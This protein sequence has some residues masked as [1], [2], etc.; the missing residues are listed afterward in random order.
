MD[1]LWLYEV[2]TPT[3]AELAQLLYLEARTCGST[4]PFQ[5]TEAQIGRLEEA[6]LCAAIDFILKDIEG[7]TPTQQEFT[8]LGQSY[9]VDE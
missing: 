9:G 7:R 2:R 6:N 4:T 5:L 3:P 1:S 8:V